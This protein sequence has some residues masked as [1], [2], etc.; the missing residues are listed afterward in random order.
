MVDATAVGLSNEPCAGAR[1]GFR[2]AVSI[3]TRPNAVAGGDTSEAL[4]ESSST[5][6]AVLVEKSFVVAEDAPLG[7]VNNTFC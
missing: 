4:P 3:S 5:T 7:P 2:S 6:D 1:G